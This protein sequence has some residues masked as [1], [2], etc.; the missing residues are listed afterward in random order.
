MTLKGHTGLVKGLTWDPVGKYIASQADDHS[1]KVWRTMDWQLETNITKPFSEVR[2]QTSNCWPEM[3]V[4]DC[5]YFFVYLIFDLLILVVFKLFTF[6]FSFFLSLLLW[7]SVAAPHTSWGWA[8]LQMVSTWFQLTPWII[9]GPQLRSSNV[10]AGKPTWILWVI[11]KLLLWWLVF[12]QLIHVSQK[13]MH[14]NLH[15]G[16]Y[17]S[18]CFCFDKIMIIFIIVQ[19]L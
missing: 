15:H 12:A 19:A 11:E 1:L 7:F 13:S 16:F 10:T 5:I 8:G 6:T 4:W 3:P 2:L 18:I 17:C 9:L 14:W